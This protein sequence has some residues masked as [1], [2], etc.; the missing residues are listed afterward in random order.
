M[1]AGRKLALVAIG[2]ALAAAFSSWN[3]VAAPFGLLVGLAAA[4]IAFRAIRLGGRRAV[5]AAGLG[6]SL[7]AV[8]ASIVV[9]ALTA[10]VGRDPT[11]EAVVS[12]PTGDEATKL[13]DQEAER[14]RAA[15]ERARQEL[16]KVGGDPA[17]SAGKAEGAA[18]R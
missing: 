14:T 13:L 12:G 10:G 18:G 4:F 11:G 5:A 6:L 17:T 3:P 2:F 1:G 8:A 16:G 15:R 9:M 7:L